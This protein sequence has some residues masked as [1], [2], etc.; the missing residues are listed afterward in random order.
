MRGNL[1]DLKR[2]YERTFWEDIL[3]FWLERGVDT[4][5]G[6][7]F[8]CFSND[9]SRLVSTDKYVW[10][11]GRFVWTLSRMY[12][13]LTD[14]EPGQ[15]DRFVEYA[16]LGADFLMENVRLKSGNCAFIL[17]REGRPKKPPGLNQYDVSTYTDTF[18]VYGL[19][20]Y[21]RVTEDSK[22]F[23]FAVD[24]FRSLERRIAAGE[25][26]TEPLPV[27]L[28]YR[29]QCL[30]MIMLETTQELAD[31]AGQFNTSLAEEL[32]GKSRAYAGEIMETFLQTDGKLLE[33]LSPEG[34]PEN[35]LLDRYVAPGH[36]LESMWF[37]MNQ[38]VRQKND[39]LLKQAAKVASG[40]VDLYW[41]EENGG[42]YL[43]T[44]R[45]G[46]KPRGNV[47]AHLEDHVM[48][49]KLRDDWD[50]KIWWTH[51]EGLY[52]LL[53]A[54]QHTG[55]EELLDRLW[56]VK[57]YT[58]STFPNPNGKEWIF[59]RDRQGNPVDKLIAMPVKDPFHTFR[60]LLN[61]I[62]CLEEMGV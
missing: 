35:A 57:D 51:C 7:Y 4:E 28:G 18:V 56:K 24:L 11:Q 23:D 25:F 9:A 47:P 36:T 52:A 50:N 34:D 8:T 26:K 42:I 53:L 27:P 2:L 5:Y 54:F 1:A 45:D 48:V 55:S 62:R 32:K 41:D 16:G 17:D 12:D 38:A 21:A 61:S 43:Y 6:G 33:L 13:Q 59:I 29:T 46:G 49:K 58:F 44:D 30:P 10:S 20:E 3:P 14:A 40:T 60:F 37:V 22:P 31:T 19:S 39:P 15:R